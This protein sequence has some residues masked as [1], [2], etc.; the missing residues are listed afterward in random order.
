VPQI[1]SNNNDNHTLSP[2]LQ[3]KLSR[4]LMSGEH[5]H[6][7]GAPSYWGVL[8]MLWVLPIFFV[9]GV[10]CLTSW[11]RELSGSVSG[12][13]LL[14]LPSLFVIVPASIL[15]VLCGTVYII[16]DRRLLSLHPWLEDRKNTS[17]IVGLS[18]ED[19]DGVYVDWLKN[20][21][22]HIYF[23]DKRQPVTFDSAPYIWTDAPRAKDAVALMRAPV[24][25]P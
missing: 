8:K 1:W 14:L 22:G 7:V 18:L 19:L 11:W 12:A 2:R 4:T 5:V 15:F 9:A 24:S 13:I 21:R 20:G 16:T 17:D 6:Y 3:G 10:C 23:N 25:P